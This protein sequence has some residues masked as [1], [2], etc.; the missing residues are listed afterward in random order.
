MSLNRAGSAIESWEQVRGASPAPSHR[1]MSFNPVGTWV[2]PVAHEDPV[3][4]F[5]V[6]KVKRICECSDGLWGHKGE[7]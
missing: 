7:C 5:Q 6:S 1:K 4:A 2:P 3:R